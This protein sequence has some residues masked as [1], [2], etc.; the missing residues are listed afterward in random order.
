[1]YYPCAARIVTLFK[2]KKESWYKFFLVIFFFGVVVVVVFAAASPLLDD[3]HRFALL[4]S[5][6]FLARFE[7]CCFVVLVK[8]RAG[9]QRGRG[10]GRNCTKCNNDK[11]VGRDALLLQMIQRSDSRFRKHSIKKT[12]V[13]ERAEY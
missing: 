11:Q 8:C 7:P 6:E 1:M 9:K 4:L 5:L 10:Y 3:N 2:T 12:R 13:G